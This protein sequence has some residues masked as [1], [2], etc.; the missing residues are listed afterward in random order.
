MPESNIKSDRN[1]SNGEPSGER[2]PLMWGPAARYA[3]QPSRQASTPAS[4]LN[5]SSAMQ[6]SEAHIWT[7]KNKGQ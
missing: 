4:P 5:Y 1:E 2:R 7:G 3:R 6:K